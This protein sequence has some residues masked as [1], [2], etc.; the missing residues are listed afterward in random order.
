MSRSTTLGAFQ[1]IEGHSA[2]RRRGTPLLLVL[3]VMLV[4]EQ[5]F[6]LR[7]SYHPPVAKGGPV[8]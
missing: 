1:W 8:L 6:A 4:V 7:L 2:L 5:L 3:A